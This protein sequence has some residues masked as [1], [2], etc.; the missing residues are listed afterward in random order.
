[1]CKKIIIDCNGIT[2]VK[3]KEKEKEKKS[4]SQYETVGLISR[5]YVSV[6]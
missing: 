4:L 3:D 5:H 6:E 2:Y 1:M